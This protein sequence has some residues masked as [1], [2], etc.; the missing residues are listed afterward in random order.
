MNQKGVRVEFDKI[1]PVLFGNEHFE[2]PFGLNFAIKPGQTIQR[3]EKIKVVPLLNDEDEFVE[4][5]GGLFIIEG[6]HYIILLPSS[7]PPIRDNKLLLNL[8]SPELNKND[9]NDLL[10]NWHHKEIHEYA[11][12]GRKEYQTQ[13]I[14]FF[15]ET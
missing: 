7:K 15:W 14:R 10:L 13:L 8:T 3:K 9:W 1:L 6:F 11:K 4:L 5:A 2:K 12:R